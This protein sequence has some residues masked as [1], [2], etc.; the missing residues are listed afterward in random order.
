MFS[1]GSREYPDSAILRG[2]LPKPGDRLN[3]TYDFGDCWEHYLEREDIIQ[4]DQAVTL[5]AC[6]EGSGACPP[7]DCGGPWGYAQL[8]EALADPG[9]PSHEER[10]DW[11]GLE[12]A[13]E[14]DLAAFSVEAANGRLSRLQATPAATTAGSAKVVRT[15]PRAR[16]KKAKRKR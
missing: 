16:K 4:N 10:L 8:K 12:S 6:L 9:H 5:P 11:L 2:L 14:L 13:D 7:E 15:Q 3:Y 1:D